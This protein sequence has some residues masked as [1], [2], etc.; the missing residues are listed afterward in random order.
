LGSVPNRYKPSKVGY[1]S[2]TGGAIRS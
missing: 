1:S 2:S